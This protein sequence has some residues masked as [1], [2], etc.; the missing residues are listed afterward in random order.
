MEVDT[1]DVGDVFED[2]GEER[3]GRGRFNERGAGMPQV[4]VAPVGMVAV[5]LLRGRWC[6]CWCQICGGGGG[7][8]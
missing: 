7:G 3:K 5:V 8:M 4:A 1:E 6:W 2:K